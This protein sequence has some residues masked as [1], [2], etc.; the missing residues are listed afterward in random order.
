MRR[1]DTDARVGAWEEAQRAGERD[2]D[3]AAYLL[4]CL[5]A[6]ARGNGNGDG[7][8]DGDPDAA[9]ADTDDEA[10]MPAPVASSAVAGG[11]P[12]D[13]MRLLARVAKFYGFSH[14]ELMRMPW[15]A[16]LGYAREADIM[17]QEEQDAYTR[18][19]SGNGRTTTTTAPPDEGDAA[20]VRSASWR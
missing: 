3:A 6:D 14:R 19:N 17:N 16:F 11:K 15:R 9:D 18:A 13:P 20:W 7:N 4:A 2:P 10:L 5:R 12:F 8:G 1:W